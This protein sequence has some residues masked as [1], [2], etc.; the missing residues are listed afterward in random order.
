MKRRIVTAIV[1]SSML[2]TVGH[3]FNKPY[4]AATKEYGEYCVNYEM[5]LDGSGRGVSYPVWWGDEVTRKVEALASVEYYGTPEE[6][7]ETVLGYAPIFERW[8][9]GHGGEIIIHEAYDQG[10]ALDTVETLKAQ[11]YIPADYVSPA[12]A[13]VQ[14]PVAE[15]TVVP[16]TQPQQ[17]QP[18]AVEQ[19]PQPQTNDSN[20]SDTPVKKESIVEE[21]VESETVVETT[22]SEETTVESTEESV[23]SE[24]VE[25]ETVEESSESMETEET[26]V[27][28]E[29]DGFPVVP[30]LSGLVIFIGLSVGGVL[31]WKKKK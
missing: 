29:K 15:T 20:Q 1:V 5:D 31:L 16:E 10:Y 22:E 8:A 7:S 4:M 6:I 9:P 23:E 17:T 26:T 25:S 24:I 21:T 27:E 18:A 2:L 19:T 13:Q 12:A 30:V 11:G 14:Q 3:M 28:E